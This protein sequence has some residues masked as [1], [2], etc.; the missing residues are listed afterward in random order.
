MNENIRTH[1]KILV[2]A[3]GQMNRLHNKKGDDNN[4]TFSEG[5]LDSI[6]RMVA[7]MYELLI[8][9]AKEYDESCQNKEDKEPE[10]LLQ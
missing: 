6:A 4:L 3:A 8:D 2:G 7:G 9:L 10:G 5:T 1:L